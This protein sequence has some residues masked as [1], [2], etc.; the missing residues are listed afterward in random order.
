M[1]ETNARLVEEHGVGLEMRIG[2]HTGVVVV[3]QRGAGTT[4]ENLAIGETPNVAARMQGLADPG[5][6]VVSD[7]TWRLVDGF[8]SAEPL[9]PQ[10]L[11][12]VSRPTP[13]YRI[14]ATT[15]VANPFEARITR[16]LTP[17]VS[18][19]LELAFLAKRWE[20]ATGRSCSSKAKAGSE[21]PD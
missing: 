9:G 2:L 6:V 17:L 14:V 10:V 3:G 1:R 18:R 13:V 19:E 8:F 21:N 4:R 12:G 11:K 16:S 15:G 7:A 20:Q 5:T